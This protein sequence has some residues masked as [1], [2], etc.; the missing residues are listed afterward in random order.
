M[1]PAT[2]ALALAAY[3]ATILAF[4]GGIRWGLAMHKTE[5]PNAAVRGSLTQQ[6]CSLLLRGLGVPFSESESI[7]ARA[8]H[9]VIDAAE[10]L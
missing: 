5:E 1:P 6:R 9:E 2:I 4:L 7:S 3:A 8:M 10:P